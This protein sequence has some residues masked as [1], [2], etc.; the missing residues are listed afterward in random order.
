MLYSEIIATC[1][2]IHTKQTNTLRGQHVEWNEM[3]VYVLALI[4]LR[5]LLLLTLTFSSY[6]TSDA[7]YFYFLSRPCSC[8]FLSG[9]SSC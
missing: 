4:P 5:P 3:C 1:S 2:D 9:S 7:S 8:Y 6:F